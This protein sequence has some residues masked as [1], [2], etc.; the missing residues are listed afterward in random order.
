MVHRCRSIAC[1]QYLN[2]TIQAQDNALVMYS[3]AVA[4]CGHNIFLHPA[5]G[6]GRLSVEV[7]HDNYTLFDA[8]VDVL[9]ADDVV[10]AEIAASLDLDQFERNL[11][12]VF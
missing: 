5:L 11:A 7:A 1:L 12:G 2:E 8:L 10:L 6:E 3:K 9:N 4:G